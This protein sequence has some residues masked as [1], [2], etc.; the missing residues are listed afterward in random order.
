MDITYL[1]ATITVKAKRH[2]SQNDFGKAIG[3]LINVVFSDKGK[4][5]EFHTSRKRKGYTFSTLYNE[6]ISNGYFKVDEG[7]IAQFYLFTENVN[8]INLIEENLFESS[9]F[10]VLDV[11]V[12]EVIWKGPVK[13]IQVKNPILLKDDSSGERE[14]YILKPQDS[15]EKKEKYIA[16]L[17]RYI[18]SDFEYITGE[19]LP[20][21]FKYIID[22]IN[23]KV[24]HYNE[25][26]KKLIGTKGT[27]IVDSTL[28]GKIVTQHLVTYGIGN[29][30]SYLGA[31]SIILKGD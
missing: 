26:N 4:W 18:K 21:D 30:S 28:L 1:R 22:V 19:Q 20:S 2:L 7:D 23:P 8:L 5:T 16:F 17:N 13:S 11:I 3:Q 29:K 6:K 15:K 31:G 12:D 25:N 9:I 14:I 27:F 24:G 10:K